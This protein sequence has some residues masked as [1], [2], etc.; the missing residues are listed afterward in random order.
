MRGSS[1]MP[2]AAAAVLLEKRILEGRRSG[3][4]GYVLAARGNRFHHR[5]QV[6][7]DLLALFSWVRPL[8]SPLPPA[9]A[10]MAGS[11]GSGGMASVCTNPRSPRTQTSCPRRT[12]SPSSR[13]T[14]PEGLGHAHPAQRPVVQSP[15]LRAVAPPAP[16][17]SSVGAF[18]GH[19]FLLWDT[20]NFPPWSAA[21]ELSPLPGQGSVSSCSRLRSGPRAPG[22]SSGH[23][24]GSRALP[25][26]LVAHTHFSEF[27]ALPEGARAPALPNFL[28]GKLREGRGPLL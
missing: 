27:C 16:L 8:T 26:S 11:S 20:L 1:R 22:A 7:G 15:A 12:S 14:A 9:S 2:I 4:T 21:W 17:K 19:M 28:L 6:G 3:V 23:V 13:R 18:R 25:F 24:R 5:C 10:T